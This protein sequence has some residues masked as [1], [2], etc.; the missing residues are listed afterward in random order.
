[1]CKECEL[2]CKVLVKLFEGMVDDCD[3]KVLIVMVEEKLV[4]LVYLI[5]CVNVWEG[6]VCDYEFLIWMMCEY[7]VVG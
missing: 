1:M 3:V 2:I 7:W 5:Y 6:G 4:S